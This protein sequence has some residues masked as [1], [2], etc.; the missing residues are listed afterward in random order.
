MATA[1]HRAA[2]SSIKYLLVLDFEAT[3][4]DGVD[5]PEIIE[6]PT[7][8]YDFHEGPWVDELDEKPLTDS[9]NHIGRPD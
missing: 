4:G 2:K 7:L 9:F 8:I 5:R 6:F 3:C 1:H